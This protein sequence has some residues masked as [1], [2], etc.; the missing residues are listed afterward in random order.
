[1]GSC[2]PGPPPPTRVLKIVVTTP[3]GIVP[4]GAMVQATAT[5]SLQSEDTEDV[6]TIVSW[7]SMDE[8]VVKVSNDPGSQG[9]VLAMGT[10]EADVTATLGSVTGT[11]HLV[12]T[13]AELVSLVVT[14]DRPVVAPRTDVACSAVGFFT[15]GSH[16]DLSSLVAWTSSEP[17][18]V[19]VSA[20]P[21]NVG[22]LTVLGPG[23]ARLHASYQKL[24]GYSDLSVTSAVLAGLVISP[25]TPY[26]SVGTRAGLRA[27]GL[28]SD[29]T[30]QPV[31]G[32]V[33]W[34]VL[35]PSLAFFSSPPPGIVEGF[36]A[37]STSAQAQ[38]GPLTATAPLT[39]SDAPL[40]A[41]EVAPALPD[42]LGI[43]GAASFTAWSTFGDQG[44]LDLSGQAT[45]STSA[46]AVVAV[47]PGSGFGLALDAGVAD[48]EA[49]FGPMSAAST[50]VV[51]PATP[52]ALLVWPPTAALTVGLP[53]AVSAERVLAD[54]TVEDATFAAGWISS[55]PTHVAVATGD[56]GGSLVIRSAATCT[57]TASLGA[58]SGE[59][60]LAASARSIQRL[61]VAPGRL[62]V[63]PGGRFALT[64]TAVFDDGSLQDVTALAAWTSSSSDVVVAGDGP[65]AG[66]G[67]A[68]DGGTAQLGATFGGAAA[69][70]AVTVAP[71]VPWL[72]V[73]PP[74]VQLHAGT[75]RP[76]RTTVV[77]PHGDALDVT[78]WTVF[79]SSDVT[80]ARLSNASGRRG[81]L[82]GLQPGSAALTA[83][84]DSLAAS[85][86]TTVDAATPE[87]LVISGPSALP[88]G[89]T[90]GY[91]A[92]AHFSDGSDQDVTLQAA[93]TSS[94]TAIVRLRGT[95]PARGSAVAVAAGRADARA[96]FTG[97]VGSAPVM[98]GN[99]TL[100]SLSLQGPGGPV[101]AG[102]QFQL[103]AVA[104]FSGG[105]VE[106][107][108]ADADW[109]SSIPAI[110]TVSIGSRA[111]VLTARQPGTTQVTV[112]FGG[113]QS[114][115]T[116]VVSAAV[117]SGLAILP[118]T[119]SAPV[120]VERALAAVGTFS[121]AS[122]FV[123]TQ[124]ARWTSS[125]PGRV[126]VSNGERTRG[127]AMGLFE[128][129]TPVSATVVRP[130]AVSISGTV[131]FT[132]QPAV[133]VGVEILPAQIA[134]SVS[135]A[136][137]RSLQ[138]IAHLS[139]GNS[140]DVTS[141]VIWSVDNSAVAGVTAG[142]Q[143]TAVDTGSTEV[144]ATLGTL[145][146]SAKVEVRP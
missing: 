118:G 112:R 98:I 103:A 56:R 99:G 50:Q 67:L 35:D 62:A 65:E 69:N 100:Q 71:D 30:A 49:V 137:T 109:S 31:T 136:P 93:W 2:H 108:T 33:Q 9:A 14:M 129:T 139:D 111:G 72:E 84:F 76:L 97:V 10:G 86:S 132:A 57:A 131:A 25:L 92:S 29:G 106:D 124:Q 18:V 94:S 59:T 6:T 74:L 145:V 45:W 125:S 87:A 19:S 95:G 1:V 53:A 121:D 117:L 73:W 51:V 55:C 107:V 8:R 110:A 96:A 122:Q 28:F 89:R 102:V 85:A 27:T 144:S 146:G 7:T 24:S 83:V 115:A 78:P 80:V 34:T 23:T 113:V 36:A 114:M 68:T 17:S 42:T 77:W 15:D 82:A 60:T 46:P 116:V 40:V 101:P 133:P 123:L 44:V 12:V 119:P 143:L 66:Q 21:G 135:G 79:A 37:G 22:A 20:A 54:G 142:G 58:L 11:V 61:E 120:G 3:A 128:G 64:A 16:A 63:G 138:A 134:L 90:A 43:G 130:D 105:V 41:L 48:V 4:L 91:Q 126:A 47:A 141:Q 75:E 104:S 52:T 39:V 127:R 140:R 70:A 32:S 38:A 26:V 13:N 5:A 81:R 88:A